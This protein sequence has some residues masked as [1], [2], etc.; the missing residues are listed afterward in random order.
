MG[1]GDKSPKM[2]LKPSGLY[3]PIANRRCLMKPGN[4]GGLSK[5]FSKETNHSRVQNC[6]HL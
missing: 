6:I 3:P 1:E 5:G 4:L 2:V